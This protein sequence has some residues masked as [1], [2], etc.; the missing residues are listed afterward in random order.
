MCFQKLFG[1][2]VQETEAA[3]LDGKHVYSFKAKPSAKATAAQAF[4]FNFEAM[5]LKAVDA[6]GAEFEL[7]RRPA[8]VPIAS[9]PVYA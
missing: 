2:H 7:R 5:T 3:F 8:A 9:R 1:D 4:K 6:G